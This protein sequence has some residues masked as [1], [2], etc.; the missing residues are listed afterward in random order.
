MTDANEVFYPRVSPE[1]SHVL[2]SGVHYHDCRTLAG[3]AGP[4]GPVGPLR[5]PVLTTEWKVPKQQTH[6]SQTASSAHDPIHPTLIH[7][8]DELTWNVW[9]T[10]S[11]RVQQR[12]GK[13]SGCVSGAL[14]A[15]SV[16]REWIYISFSLSSDFLFFCNMSESLQFTLQETWSL[17][18]LEHKINRHIY[19]WI[20]K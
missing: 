2:L 13:Y 9:A 12:E 20:K 6:E 19:K 11:P 8:S 14:T 5:E 1:T 16:S 17:E 18:L 7:R 15:I 10:V 4:S 3:H